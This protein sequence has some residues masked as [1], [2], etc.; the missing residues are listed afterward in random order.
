MG[1]SGAQM[2]GLGY[3]YEF[4]SH[5][6]WIIFAAVVLHEITLKEHKK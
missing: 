5:S 6:S 1:M 4:Q 2:R 3:R